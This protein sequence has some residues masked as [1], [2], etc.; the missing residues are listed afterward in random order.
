MG[1]TSDANMANPELSTPVTPIIGKLRMHIQD[2][3]D[4]D[5]FYI[6]SLPGCD[7]LL[8]MP[9]HYDHFILRKTVLIILLEK[10][11]YNGSALQPTGC[12]HKSDAALRRI[13]NKKPLTVGEDGCG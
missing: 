5:D 6:M 2:Y 4:T 9:W 1:P 13:K 3:V 8:G 12:C 10:Q 11:E 7:V